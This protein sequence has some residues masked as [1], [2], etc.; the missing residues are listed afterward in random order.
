MLHCVSLFWWLTVPFA[1]VFMSM[2]QG[3][4]TKTFRMC[5]VQHSMI[6]TFQVKHNLYNLVID[7]QFLCISC[8]IYLNYTLICIT[9][10]F[11]CIQYWLHITR[12]YLHRPS[13]TIHDF[14]LYCNIPALNV[15]TQTILSFLT[16][17]YLPNFT[18]AFVEILI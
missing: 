12:F 16:S 1:L 7:S 11:L 8:L 5:T 14:L 2:L 10:V 15:F 9:I 13:V 4:Q 3:N 6:I 18:Y 17:H